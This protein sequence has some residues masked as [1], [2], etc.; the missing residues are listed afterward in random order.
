VLLLVPQFSG[1]EAVGVVRCE[2]CV[3]GGKIALM[4]EAIL[5]V[6]E[7]PP[8]GSLRQFRGHRGQLS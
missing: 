8:E 7:V 3:V 6:C 5:G 1:V 4:F 2:D